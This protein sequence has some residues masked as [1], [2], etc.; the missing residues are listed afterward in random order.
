LTQCLLCSLSCEAISAPPGILSGIVVSNSP[1]GAVVCE[2]GSRRKVYRVALN[3]KGPL[4]L[5]VVSVSNG[6]LKD[7]FASNEVQKCSA[8]L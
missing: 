5:P 6:N 8:E 1:A 7:S 4:A 2:S 3:V